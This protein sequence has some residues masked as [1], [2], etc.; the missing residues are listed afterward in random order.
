MSEENELEKE[1]LKTQA[2]KAEVEAYREAIRILMGANNP[3]GIEI[4]DRMAR[5]LLARGF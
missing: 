2:A 1:K 5:S 4:V 3:Q